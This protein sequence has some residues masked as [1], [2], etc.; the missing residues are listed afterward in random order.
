VVNGD[1]LGSVASLLTSPTYG[2]DPA[3]YRRMAHAVLTHPDRGMT[4][5]AADAA[6]DRLLAASQALRDLP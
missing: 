3:M 5:D 2:Q 1:P 4:P 6:I